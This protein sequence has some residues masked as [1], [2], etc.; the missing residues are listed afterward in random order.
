MAMVA[1]PVILRLAKA[2]HCA[3]L[4]ACR[5][6]DNFQDMIAFRFLMQ[7]L[8]SNVW[9]KRM[10]TLQEALLPR[11]GRLYFGPVSIPLDSI[12]EIASMWHTHL[13]NACC[14]YW[15]S[16]LDPVVA[17]F[18]KACFFLAQD[19]KLVRYGHRWDLFALRIEYTDRKASLDV[20][21]LYGLLG[22]TEMSYDV[23]P[24]YS[25]SA[26][27]V[28]K[29]V[30]RNFLVAQPKYLSFWIFIYAPLKHKYPNLPSWAVDC[31]YVFCTSMS[32]HPKVLLLPLYA[33]GNMT[34]SKCKLLI[35]KT[36]CKYI[37]A[38]F[39]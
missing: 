1:A 10:W 4:L 26:E 15:L 35:I 14:R 25:L 8:G 29:Q 18:V 39:L 9:F 17:P 13:T 36:A 37:V 16:Y 7:Y 6:F 3:D 31:T 27:D 38:L 23:S 28:F 24:D 34:P 32:G 30:S 21:L 5:L 22:L 19:R 33:H 2:E 11:K 20:D 12:F